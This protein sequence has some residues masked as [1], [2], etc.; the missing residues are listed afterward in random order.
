MRT[1]ICAKKRLEDLREQLEE[2][3]AEIVALH[4]LNMET[5]IEMDKARKEIKD[6]EET[7]LRK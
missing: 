7:R 5:M 4:L 3:E 1:L 2:N 6:I